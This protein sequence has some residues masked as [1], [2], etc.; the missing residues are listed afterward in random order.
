MPL[1]SDSTIEAGLPRRRFLASLSAALAAPILPAFLQGA[2]DKPQVQPERQPLEKLLSPEEW[3]AAQKSPLAL[4]I[5]KVFGRGYSCAEAML[6]VSVRHLR[7]P[8]HLVW[9]A[10][11][12]GGGLGQKDLCG[13]L[14]AGIMGFG[15]ACGTLKLE[16]K[17]A[18]KICADASA[19]YW[20][21][22]KA[23]FPLRC[24]ELRPVG[25]SGD[26]CRR[27]GAL[28]AAK[29]NALLDRLVSPAE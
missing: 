7:M 4:E 17:D 25:S 29:V 21:W 22:W 11:G 19:E 28:S 12:F 3:A 9:A 1:F 2:Q 5:D 18:K 24:S 6:L 13:F 8:E 23:S 20:N 14:T 16:R 10:A 26:I 27:L 15:H